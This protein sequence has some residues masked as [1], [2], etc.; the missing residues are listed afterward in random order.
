MLQRHAL[1][2]AI[3][4]FAGLFPPASLAMQPAVEEFARQSTGPDAW[5]LAA[6]VVPAAR[7]DE[8][9]AA[10]ERVHDRDRSPW[11]L[12]V[13]LGADPLV[14]LQRAL[15][16]ERARPTL[17][18]VVAFE[19]RPSTPALLGAVMDAVMAVEPVAA[20]A[21]G[22]GSMQ[23][24]CELPW[25]G[26]LD[27]WLTTLGARGA[28]AKIRTGG[29]T[30]ELVPP[31]Q[32]VARF[33]RAC[34]SAGVGLKFTAGLHHPVRAVHPLSYASDAPRATMHGFLNVF[35]AAALIAGADADDATLH[36][37]LGETDA[38]TFTLERDGG[39]RWRS[40]SLD[41]DAVRAVRT[42][43]A[44]SFGSCSFAEP[45]QDLQELGFS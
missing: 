31:V 11:H 42:G 26:D 30:P 28:W 6:F 9:A 1:L 14:D 38:S 43:F 32:A 2:E 3:V 8:F 13:L 18:K 33:L 34:R 7:L 23:V 36:E 5:M 39:L 40:F 17:G 29:V 20:P 10:A 35:T 22:P 15:E 44:R 24:F 37:V 12:S 27:A 19:F 4:D 25:D 21:A 41:G 45:V 16:F